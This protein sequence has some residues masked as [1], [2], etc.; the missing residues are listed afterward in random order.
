M[1]KR[2]LNPAWLHAGAC[3]LVFGTL[4]ARSHATTTEFCNYVGKGCVRK[5]TACDANLLKRNYETETTANWYCEGSSPS[6][7]TCHPNVEN[8]ECCWTPSAAPACPPQRCPCATAI[9]PPEGR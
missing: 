8:G 4:V 3:V 7:Y 5:S 1:I 2:L 6:A 9:D